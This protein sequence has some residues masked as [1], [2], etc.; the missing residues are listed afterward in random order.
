MRWIPVSTLFEAMLILA[1]WLSPALSQDHSAHRHQMTPEQFAELR[2]KVPLYRE[3][4]DE[5]IMENM[6]RMGP[7][8]HVYLSDADTTGRVGVLALGHGYEPAGN[9]AFK[10]A[11]KPTADKHPTAA[12]FGMAMMTS[13]HIQSA[14]DELTEAGADTVLVMPA[15]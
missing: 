5:E 14:V 9:E 12:A 7:N 13:D 8:H 1:L 4:T 2:E 10:S 15:A 6:G 3:F 11:Y